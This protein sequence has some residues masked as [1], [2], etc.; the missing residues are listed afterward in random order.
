MYLVICDFAWV[1][2]E[3]LR[4]LDACKEGFSV[5]EAIWVGSWQDACSGLI[6]DVLEK[7]GLIWDILETHGDVFMAMEASMWWLL[8]QTSGHNH[9]GWSGI[10]DGLVGV[11]QIWNKQCVGRM[12]QCAAAHS[13]CAPAQLVPGHYDHFLICQFLY[14]KYVCLFR[15][16]EIR[17]LQ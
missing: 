8:V 5:D 9:F 15:V 7:Q 16:L 13:I 6:L 2:Q 10:E 14:Y 4:S 12:I 17:E 3:I 11:K 1:L